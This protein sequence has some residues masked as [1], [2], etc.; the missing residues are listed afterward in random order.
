MS[1]FGA[2]QTSRTRRSGGAKPCQVSTPFSGTAEGSCVLFFG[3]AHGH[4]LFQISSVTS[5]PASWAFV[6]YLVVGRTTEI[7]SDSGRRGPDD[8]R[9][10][11]LGVTDIG[12]VLR[13]PG[14]V[15]R[16]VQDATGE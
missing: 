15:R 3:H 12:D 2:S 4:R 8:P 7:G 16:G 14:V 13:V 5:L 10:P 6:S 9:E 11:R 1:R